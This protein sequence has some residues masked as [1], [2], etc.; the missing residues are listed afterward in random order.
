MN[1]NK[2]LNLCL[3]LAYRTGKRTVVAAVLIVASA[4]VD[5][6]ESVTYVGPHATG[7]YKTLQSANLS[8][9]HHTIQHAAVKNIPGY[10]KRDAPAIHLPGP[11]VNPS[12]PHGA[13]RPVQRNTVAGGTYGA[14]RRVGYRALRA[15]GVAPND[16]KQVIR[17][18]D[19]YFM[20]KLGATL[21]TPT[22]YPKDRKKQ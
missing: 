20:S 10:S 4:F 22:D 13:T 17:Q 16:A 11:A 3:L 6:K 5:H 12:T 9:G 2:R 19:N 1:S 8:D 18:A 14:E 21:N 15:G 7:S